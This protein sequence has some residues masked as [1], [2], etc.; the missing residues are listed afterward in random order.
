MS[1]LRREGELREDRYRVLVVE[2]DPLIRRMLST[3]LTGEG[4]AVS[5]SPGGPEA[6]AELGAGS[7]DI[8]VQ[9]LVKPAAG[10]SVFRAGS[11]PFEIAPESPVLI[12]SANLDRD[13]WRLTGPPNGLPRLAE[14][15]DLLAAIREL[16]GQASE[17]PRTKA[18]A[19]RRSGIVR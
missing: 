12:V 19:R 18:P 15:D 4:F 13:E 10:W 9:S 14:L 5:A 17:D 7:T 3:V 16:T 11:T 6:L 8:T 2:P 1:F